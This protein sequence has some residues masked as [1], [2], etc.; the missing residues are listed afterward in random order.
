MWYGNL[1]FSL[2]LSVLMTKLNTLIISIIIKR[3]RI[4]S[5]GYN[6]PLRCGHN[7]MSQYVSNVLEG[8]MLSSD[9]Q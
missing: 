7:V 4:S 1:S 6:S 9:K 8:S 5:L 2:Y 3:I